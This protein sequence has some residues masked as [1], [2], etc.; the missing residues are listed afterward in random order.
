M[1]L[2]LEA[3]LKKLSAT[4]ALSSET[5]RDLSRSESIS[6]LE[7]F[8]LLLLLL[9]AVYFWPT[10]RTVAFSHFPRRLVTFPQ[11][12]APQ[13]YDYLRCGSAR[14]HLFVSS[15][16]SFIESKSRS[17]LELKWQE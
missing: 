1:D 4:K 10:V 15:C 7:L 11:A 8:L 9:L 16:G 13:G 17:K 6:M 2:Q 5:N 3:T 12:I 14:S